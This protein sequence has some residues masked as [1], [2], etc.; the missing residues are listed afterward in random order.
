MHRIHFRLFL[1][2]LLMT[3]L[4]M[5]GCAPQPEWV[6]RY[7]GT[8]DYVDWARDVTVD[9][10]GNIYV[11]GFSHGD[12]TEEDVATIK[13]DPDGNELWVSRYN[14]PANGDDD[15]SNIAV[16]E[17][18]NV[19]VAGVSYGEETSGD[20]VTIK[21]DANSSELWVARYSGPAGQYDSIQ[22]MVLDGAGNI[23][24]A[25]ESYLSDSDSDYITIKYSPEGL[26][27]WIAAYDGPAN[28]WDRAEDLAVDADH[29]VYVTGA[30]E[31][32]ANGIDY[33][34]VRYDTNGNEL[35]VARYEGPGNRY[36]VD[37]AY[38]LALDSWNHVFVTGSSEGAGTDDDFLTI[39]YDSNGNELWTAR[40]NGP[41]DGEDSA[42]S[43]AV[44]GEGNL[45]VAGTSAY[46]YATV[47]YD[48]TGAQRWAVRYEGP[49]G[50]MDVLTDLALDL[51][52]NVYVTGYVTAK[53]FQ[54]VFELFDFA[55][56]KYDANGRRQW[57]ALYNGPALWSDSGLAI[58]VDNAGNVVV[59]G[60]S[61]GIGSGP[62][63]A[64]IKYPQ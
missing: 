16:D 52:G 64:T 31:G 2:F 20:F 5:M 4:I 15:A 12:V 27:L 8:E 17:S 40:Y 33:A 63:Y 7:N 59:T 56:L 39:R 28:G 36:R 21:Y 3:L 55:T 58:A 26:E 1:L 54:G 24:V 51:D 19:Y 22:A 25:G 48:P 41:G 47:K 62:D 9:E 6:A 57:A 50:R 32:I 23:Y 60:R 37:H 30:S 10:G 43:I 34:T 53:V 11:T 61:N 46:D 29:N 38:A 42:K 13:Y 44:D 14:G 45:I 18:G 49:A 35:W